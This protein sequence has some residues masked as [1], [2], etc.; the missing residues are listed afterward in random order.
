[1]KF[2]VIL[3]NHAIQ[4]QSPSDIGIWRFLVRFSL[5][6]AIVT[7]DETLDQVDLTLD[8]DGF[9]PCSRELELIESW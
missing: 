1:M 3:P 4:V 6:P 5:K 2:R 8:E 7:P 9:D